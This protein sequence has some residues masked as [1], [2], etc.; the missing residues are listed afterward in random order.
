MG[1]ISDTAYAPTPMGHTIPETPHSGKNL[2]IY[3]PSTLFSKARSRTGF[4]TDGETH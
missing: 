2:C 3:L 1:E 4:W